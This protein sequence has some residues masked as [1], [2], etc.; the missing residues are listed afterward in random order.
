VVR[1][2][3]STVGSVGG[4]GGELAL[5]LREFLRGLA[6]AKK[7]AAF[8]GGEATGIKKAVEKGLETETT[9]EI[10]PGFARLRG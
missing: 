1:F 6:A 3:C 8:T 2:R 7:R 5:H 10:L 4:V 9:A